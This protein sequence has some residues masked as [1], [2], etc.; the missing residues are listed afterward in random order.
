LGLARRFLHDR[1]VVC[2]KPTRSQAA[3]ILGVDKVTAEPVEL[4][5]FIRDHFGAHAGEW[6]W[7]DF[8]TDFDDSV[9]K[10]I[11]DSAGVV[12]KALADYAP[13]VRRVYPCPEVW[14][15]WLWVNFE[16]LWKAVWYESLD[17]WYANRVG[18]D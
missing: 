11:A 14:S 12:L 13:R 1:G 8:Y 9:I 18:E 4:L 15:A 17:R 3:D 10:E 5:G 2:E 6:R 7:W 16:T